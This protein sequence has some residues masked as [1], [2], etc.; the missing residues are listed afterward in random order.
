[1]KHLLKKAIACAGFCLCGSAYANMS[2]SMELLCPAVENLQCKPSPE[3]DCSDTPNAYCSGTWY[4]QNKNTHMFAVRT[5]HDCKGTVTHLIVAD[6]GFPN[7]KTVKC[8]YELKDSA[9]VIYKMAL[10][11]E[12]DYQ[13]CEDQTVV[14]AGTQCNSK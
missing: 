4:G 14:S 1:M 3:A 11:N 10:Y 7:D 9:G 12:M 6:S 2:I 8:V 5:M 13:L